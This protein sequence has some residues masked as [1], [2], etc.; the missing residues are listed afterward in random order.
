MLCLECV[1]A[2]S[3]KNIF[4][5][6]KRVNIIMENAMKK[7]AVVIPIYKPEMTEDETMSFLQGLKILSSYPIVIVSHPNL[8]LDSY[9][10]V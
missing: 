5:K 3:N 1:F 2:I 6:V 8:N 4:I 10:A 7:V 9:I